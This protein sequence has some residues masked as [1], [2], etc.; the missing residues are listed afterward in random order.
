MSAPTDRLT[1]AMK[2]FHD[3]TARRR[4]FRGHRKTEWCNTAKRGRAG[5]E[6]SAKDNQAIE[7]MLKGSR[8]TVKLENEIAKLDAEGEDDDERHAALMEEHRA[9]R[10]A[11]AIEAGVQIRYAEAMG[12]AALDTLEDM[13][14]EELAAMRKSLTIGE[15]TGNITELVNA[16][17]GGQPPAKK[18]KKMP[19]SDGGSSD[20]DGGSG[21]GPMDHKANGSSFVV[22]EVLET[23]SKTVPGETNKHTTK[24]S[25]AKDSAAQ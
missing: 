16:E 15:R 25:T 11:T 3:R 5:M 4:G 17:F 24:K 2:A 14:T 7:K 19:K 8:S 9:R 18:P 10:V 12:E 21:G 1:P 6:E 23:P 13:S 22:E 20:G